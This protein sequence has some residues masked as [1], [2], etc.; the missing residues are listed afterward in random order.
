MLM[1]LA[2]YKIISQVV[3]NRVKRVL[4]KI[5]SPFQSTFVEGRFIFDDYIIAHEIMHSF[6]K[7]RKKIKMI[8][9]KLDMSKA[10]DRME[11]D[12]LLKSS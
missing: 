5:I 12:L 10:Y 9:F 6:K 7:K 3:A 2:V 1:T 4:H 8:G 11:S